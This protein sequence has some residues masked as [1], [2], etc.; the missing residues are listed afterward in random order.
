MVKLHLLEWLCNKLL[1]HVNKKTVLNENLVRVHVRWT[2]KSGNQIGFNWP[3]EY[4]ASPRSF[5][6][7][8]KLSRKVIVITLF[9]C[10]CLK[11]K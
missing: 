1:F 9:G 3:I 7:V 8:S 6:G 4:D 10:V 11:D 2:E 5:L